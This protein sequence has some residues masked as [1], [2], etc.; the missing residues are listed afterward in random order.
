[1]ESGQEERRSQRASSVHRKK[2]NSEVRKRVNGTVT[3]SAGS[4]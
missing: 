3:L 2:M 4:G 1:M